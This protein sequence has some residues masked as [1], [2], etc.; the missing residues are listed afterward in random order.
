M[1]TPSPSTPADT[2]A[3]PP[4]YLLVRTNP[5]GRIDSITV[6]DGFD[7]RDL[8]Y[9]QTAWRLPDADDEQ[10]ECGI[11]G[12]GALPPGAVTSG[13]AGNEVARASSR[14]WDSTQAQ[15]PQLRR[16][17]GLL[18]S[19]PET[20]DAHVSPISP[21]HVGVVVTDAM[22]ETLA[23]ALDPGRGWVLLCQLRHDPH[24]HWD[25]YAVIAPADAVPERIAAEF[26]RNVDDW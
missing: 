26:V 6:T 2:P 13:M 4:L 8:T 18:M 7:P 15:L 19:G 17:A 24:G 1:T 14:Y 25:E 12:D 23:V 22:S 5:D 11:A 21:G 9:D 10:Q 3:Q 16:I 20:Y